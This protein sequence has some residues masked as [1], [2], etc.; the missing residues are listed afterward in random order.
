MPV[1]FTEKFS[2][3]DVRHAD[4]DVFGG[5]DWFSSNNLLKGA[6]RFTQG[7]SVM[8][9]VSTQDHGILRVTTHNLGQVYIRRDFFLHDHEAGLTP[10]DLGTFG[11]AT[12]AA[13][14]EAVR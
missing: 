4:R 1:S 7:F 3:D 9:F 13:D 14:V 11:S 8:N 2:I 12:G 6:A 10:L 5:Y